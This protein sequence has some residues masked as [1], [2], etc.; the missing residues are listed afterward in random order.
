MSI[1]LDKVDLAM[2]VQTSVL[3][4][5]LDYQAQNILKLVESVTGQTEQNGDKV[6]GAK[7]SGKGSRLNILA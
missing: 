6:A 7:E 4:K 3:K 1:L 5:Q 2:R